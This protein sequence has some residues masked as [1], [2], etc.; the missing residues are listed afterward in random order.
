[1]AEQKETE[2]VYISKLDELSEPL[3]AAENWFIVSHLSSETDDEK[4]FSSNKVQYSTLQTQ[5]YDYLSAYMV[6]KTDLELSGKVDEL[7]GKI[8]GISCLLDACLSAVVALDNC[9]NNV[10]ARVEALE[11]SVEALYNQ[12]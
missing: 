12:N 8:D 6:S 4:Q 5:L 1:M 2:Y 10:R 7:S 11:L 3:S 9:R